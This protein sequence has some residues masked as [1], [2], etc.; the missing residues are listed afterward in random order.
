MM[1][2]NTLRKEVRKLK[3]FQQITYKEISELLECSTS[4]IYSWL[5]GNFNFSPERKRH[6]QAIIQDLYLEE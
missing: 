3:A 5:R 4:S 1:N 6:L 2:D